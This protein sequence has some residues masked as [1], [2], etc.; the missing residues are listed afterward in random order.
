MSHFGDRLTET[1]RKTGTPLCM[2]IDPH[3]GMI[4]AL[5]GDATAAPGSSAAIS[6][7]EDFSMTCLEAAIGKVAAIKPQAA[8][9]EQQGPA[10][11]QILQN[12]GRAAIEARLLVV[13]DAK[14][15]DIGST[16]SAY[17]NGWIGHDAP[18]P[19]DALTINPWL[20][21]DTLE[22][23]LNRAD[24]TGS[25][26]FILNRTSNPGSAELQGKTVDGTPLYEHL[27]MMLAPLAAAR[28][29]GSGVSSLG[30][31]AGATWPEEAEALRRH[32]PHTPFLIPGFGAQGAGPEKATIGLIRGRTGWEGGL[33]NSTRGLIFPKSA[34]AAHT[35]N[36][37][38]MAIDQ[39]IEENIAVLN[40]VY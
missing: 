4:P 24:A 6:A 22:P 10:G 8:F 40:S 26:V 25:G 33:V 18:F 37:W 27:A 12:L 29:G 36:D 35:M 14:R 21:L 32:L 23:F 20:G 5:F 31:V 9:F 17:A 2:G 13:M 34:A 19:S 11:M 28:T 38:R 39:T 3:I 7:I 15:G 1:N 16:S 30:I